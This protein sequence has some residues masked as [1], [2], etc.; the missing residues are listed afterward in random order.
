MAGGGGKW[1]GIEKEWKR[2]GLH[3]LEGHEPLRSLRAC[4]A[5]A[6]T[7]C[8]LTLLC[9]RRFGRSGE[10]RHRRAVTG[11]SC[12]YVKHS[13]LKVLP[14]Y[15][16]FVAFFFPWWVFTVSSLSPRTSSFSIASSFGISYIL[17]LLL[18]ADRLLFLGSSHSVES[19]I[20]LSCLRCAGLES[21][22]QTGG[23]GNDSHGFFVV[24]LAAFIYT[25]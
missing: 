11:D 7:G 25:L 15:Q 13:F 22:Q 3:I 2:I 23:G 4:R 20:H 8:L 19:P 24:P 12:H 16:N 10:V 21:Y 5:A 18:P 9:C 6:G 1:R 17:H 14:A